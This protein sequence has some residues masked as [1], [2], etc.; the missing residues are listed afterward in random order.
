MTLMEKMDLLWLNGLSPKERALAVKGI[1]K[2]GESM[3]P[4]EDSK[5]PK[6]EEK[7]TPWKA[8]DLFGWG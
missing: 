2:P 5:E 6:V 4:A 1:L 8:K 3:E 7:H